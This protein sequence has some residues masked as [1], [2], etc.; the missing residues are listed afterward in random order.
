MVQVSCVLD[1]LDSSEVKLDVCRKEW[2]DSPW[3]KQTFDQCWGAETCSSNS[4]QEP[5]VQMF[6]AAKYGQNPW[7]LGNQT[8]GPLKKIKEAKPGYVAVLIVHPLLNR[9]VQVKCPKDGTKIS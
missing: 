5:P 3:E 9:G 7:A 4:W 8:T 2:M 6:S 1:D